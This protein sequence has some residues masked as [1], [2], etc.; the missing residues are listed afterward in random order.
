MLDVA[1]KQLT[2]KVLAQQHALMLAR[3]TTPSFSDQQ[4]GD[5][6]AALNLF[7]NYGNTALPYWDC[8]D[9]EEPGTIKAEEA[10]MLQAEWEAS[11]GK[12]DDPTVQ[13]KLAQYAQNVTPVKTV[14]IDA[15]HV[16]KRYL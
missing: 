1:E 10:S 13:A 2:L 4:K 15:K 7:M 8:W 6:D 11:F 12:L 16:I 3:A 9:I 5:L 14:A